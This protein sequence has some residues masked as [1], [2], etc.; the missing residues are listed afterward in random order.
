MHVHVAI[1]WPFHNLLHFWQ[2]ISFSSEKINEICNTR[3][4]VHS[5]DILEQVAISGD[6][7]SLTMWLG[8]YIPLLVEPAPPHSFSCIWLHALLQFVM[9][10]TLG[11]ILSL[12]Q[13][14]SVCRVRRVKYTS[15]RMHGW[16]GG[17]VEP[18]KMWSISLFA[19]RVSSGVPTILTHCS[20]TNTSQLA[21]RCDTSFSSPSSE[22]SKN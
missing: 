1:P 2:W 14:I 15:L 22:Y 17:L 20:A 6:T 19:C 18:T 13:H 10:Q 11:G 16:H 5:C 4:K 7:G 8:L 9:R 12:A 3:L 21:T